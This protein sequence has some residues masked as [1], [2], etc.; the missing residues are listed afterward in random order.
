MPPIQQG[1]PQKRQNLSTKPLKSFNWTKIPP[2][3]I[4]QTVW[5]KLDESVIHA[6]L[7]PE[8]ADFEALFAAKETLVKIL[9]TK[10]TR[11]T[12]GK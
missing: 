8:Y 11:S 2:N 9:D 12:Y 5:Q 7:L 10:T 1:P 3:K 4:N 6:Q